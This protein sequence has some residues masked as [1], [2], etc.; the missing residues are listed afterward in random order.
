MGESGLENEHCMAVFD[1]IFI[2]L[3]IPLL[4][5]ANEIFRRL[6]SQKISPCL[7][8]DHFVLA[9]PTLLLAG[10]FHL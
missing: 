3:V 1:E 8:V 2:D 4:F 9:L 10:L 6:L 7:R 5:F